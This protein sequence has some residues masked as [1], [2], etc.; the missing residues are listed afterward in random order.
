MEIPTADAQVLKPVGHVAQ[1]VGDQVAH[2]AGALP[3]ALYGEKLRMQEGVALF[4]AQLGPAND[5]QI[6]GFVFQRNENHAFGGGWLLA[7]GDDAASAHPV[8]ITR[9]VQGCVGAKAV[10]RQP[11]AQQCHRV[12]AQAEA[13]GGVIPMDVFLLAGGG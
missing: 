13:Q 11:R 2:V 10:L 8:A 9:I 1:L 7:Q 12:S 5:L 3:A 4:A 6:A